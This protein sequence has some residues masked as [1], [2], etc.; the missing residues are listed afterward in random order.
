MRFALSFAVLA[1]SAGAATAQSALTLD[2]AIGLAR[3]NNPLYQQVANQRRSA[4][5]QLR[6]AY[7]R[8]LP[9]LSANMS[10]RYQQTGQ[11]FFQ[12]VAL[13][14][15]SDQV[16]S[17]YNIGLNYNLN[18]AVLFAPGL[19]RANRDAAEAE[20]TGQQEF[21]RAAVTQQYISVLQA[22][23]R[24]ALQD[25]LLR[26]TRGQLEL[27]QARMSVGAGTILDVRRAEVALGQ[28]EVVALQ[29][30]NTAQVEKLRLFQTMGIAQ[31]TDVQLTTRLTIAPVTFTL[32]SLK[33]LAKG[34][35]PGLNAMRSRQIAANA[36]V[37]AE[38]GQYFPTIGLSTGW[39]GQTNSLTD[40]NVVLSRATNGFLGARAGCFFEDSLRSAVAGMARLPCGAMTFTAA[41]STAALDANNKFPFAFTKAPQSFSVFVSLPLF[42]N[43]SRET[44]VQQ[45]VI[46]RDDARYAVRGRELQLAADVTQM[47]LNL[48]TAEKTLAIQEVNATR[49]REELSFAEERYRVG[50][51]TFLE[52]TTSRGNFEQAQIDRL[53]AIYD[54][55]KAFALLENAVGRP[56][57]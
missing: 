41:D 8:L 52:V 39:G 24:A 48:K 5:G 10:G 14:A 51:V 3:R 42:D 21:L 46:Q 40:D 27:A 37:K 50:A 32:D 47:F 12:G 16:Q 54:Y 31:P 13:S 36:G 18:A 6:Q 28:G 20:L 4:D 7:A 11:Q 55:H 33:N 43:L 44:R 35:N 22:E 17:S 56:L 34:Y 23:A 25:T 45:A 38:R 49:A 26:T 30:Q 2:E 29:A 57:R 1:L 19:Y 9:S 15:A 53:N